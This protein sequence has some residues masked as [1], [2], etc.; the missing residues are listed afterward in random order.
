MSIISTQ[1]YVWHQIYAAK[2]QDLF[3]HLDEV[4]AW[5]SAAGIDGFETWFHLPQQVEMIRPLLRRHGVRMPS[6][7]AGGKMHEADWKPAVE[8]ILSKARAAQTLGVKIVAVNPDPIAW[9][10]PL[11]KTD[12]QLKTQAEALSVLGEKLKSEGLSLAYHMHDAELRCGAREL[13]HMMQGTDPQLVGM[14]MDTHWI[15]R[16]AGNSQVALYDMVKMYLP[17]VRSLHLRQSIKG[18]W[19]ETFG[20]GDIDYRTLAALLKEAN[21]DGPLVL[22]QCQ[23]TGTP[24]ELDPTERHRR[25]C[26]YA[27]Q[28]FVI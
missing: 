25:S 14:C 13:H 3:E 27:R 18:V 24:Q 15:Y 22:E 11:D 12:D 10:K 1:A 9:G 8:T 16:G 2:K 26:A 23:E 17:R 21:F 19:S 28:V 6:M 5:V 7:Y 4:L 20:D